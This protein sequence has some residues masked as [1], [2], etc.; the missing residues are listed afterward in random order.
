MAV[1]G[2]NYVKASEL[3]RTAMIAVATINT[4]AATAI[5]IRQLVL[6]N[7]YYDLA[8]EARDYWKGTFKPLEVAFVNE[9]K[10]MPM[11]TPQYDVT[12]GRF[13]AAVK[14]QFKRAYDSVGA[15]ASRYC[16]GLTATLMRDAMVAQAAAEGDVINLAYR[17]EDGRKQIFD[18]VRHGRR[19]QALTLGRNMIAESTTYASMANSTYGSLRDWTTGNA[20]GA[21]KEY[22]SMSTVAN[23]PYG[24]Q[25]GIN[26][27]SGLNMTENSG[28]APGLNFNTGGIAGSYASN[29]SSSLTS[30]N[31]T[32][33]TWSGIGTPHNVL[34]GTEEAPGS[35]NGSIP[36]NSITGFWG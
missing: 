19:M 34:N 33:S 12:A 9:V 3:A 29:Y 31:A 1:D 35:P 28:V 4:V 11:Y 10:N 21:W 36:Y 16:T 20:N 14:Q 23:S 32:F 2:K 27:T 26:G 6:A 13:L 15:T 24:G 25:R 17:Y 7:K 22:Y 8:K 30:S 18:E 5:A